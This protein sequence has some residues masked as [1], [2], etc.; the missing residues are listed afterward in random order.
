MNTVHFFW[1]DSEE[2][3]IRY[4]NIANQASAIY[5]KIDPALKDAFYEL[6]LYPVLGAQLMN[7]KF[8][9]AKYSI[10]EFIADDRT[11]EDS[12][13]AI[14]TAARARSAFDSI[15]TIT[16]IYNKQ[17]AG[18][19]WDGIMSWH[20]RDQN[21][22]TMPLAMVDS[23]HGNMD[24]LNY[25]LRYEKVPD[26]SISASDFVNKKD[27]NNAKVEIIRGLGINGRGVTVHFNNIKNINDSAYIEFN[28]PDKHGDYVIIVKCLPGF[29]TEFSKYLG[30][31]I[32]MNDEKPIAV[33]VHT[34]A[35]SKE[36]RE[37][38]IRGYATGRS[39]HHFNSSG[40]NKLRIWL[41]DKN[42]VINTIEFY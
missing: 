40:H 34:E 24:S 32:S 22:F 3:L 36:W 11:A 6:I 4:N 21:V 30:Y 15:A 35:E 16:R 23:F 27:G 29:D 31:S 8:L 19:K 37:N 2:R 17:I 1:E 20:P 33:N 39:M 14:E 9:L 13:H 25:A 7:E 26:F 41:K 38:V 5:N 42:L 10:G 12:L 18:G 28:L